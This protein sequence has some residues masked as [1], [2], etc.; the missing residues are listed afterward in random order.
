MPRRSPS[1]PLLS[2]HLPHPRPSLSLAAALSP[3]A[4]IRVALL[5]PRLLRR[6]RISLCFRCELCEWP[7]ESPAALQPRALTLQLG[8]C[9]DACKGEYNPPNEV[10]VRER[11]PRLPG[12]SIAATSPCSCH[13]QNFDRP[14]TDFPGHQA[15]LAV[16]VRAALPAT[17][18]LVCVLVHGGGLDISP[19]YVPCDAIVSM[20]YPGMQGGPALWDVLTGVAPPAGRTTLSWFTS[21]Q[22]S[23][24]HGKGYT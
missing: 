4:R 14:N 24:A 22:V 6:T 20:G 15:A 23:G 7:D 19:L 9:S 3:R 17:S 16:A 18:R 10:E 1:Q 8:L 11:A 13:T 21:E 2:T 5:L 12:R